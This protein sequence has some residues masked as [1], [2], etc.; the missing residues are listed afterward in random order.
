MSNPEN[1][2]Y[3]GLSAFD[4]FLTNLKALFVKKTD[5]ASSSTSGISKLYNDTGNNTDGSINQKKITEELSTKLPYSGG[6]LTGNIYTTPYYNSTITNPDGGQV[7][8]ISKGKNNKGTHPSSISETH[9]LGVATDKTGDIS[10]LHKYGHVQTS[11]NTSGVTTTEI[12]AFKDTA[13]ANNSATISVSIDANGNISTSAPTPASTSNDTNIATTAFVKNEVSNYTLKTDITSG[14]SNGS[15]AVAGIDIPVTGLSAVATSG[16][17]NDLSNTPTNHVTSDTDQNITSVKTFIGTKTIH[18]KQSGT[19]DKLGFTL[20]TN[21]DIEKGYLEYNPTNLVNGI[22]LLMLGNYA[23]S[24]NALAYTGFRRYSNISGANGAYNLLTPLISDAKT[25]FNLTTTYTNFYLTLGVTDGTNMV[26]TAK[27]GVLDIST[28]LPTVPTNI[29]AFTN[30]AGYITSNG[31]ASSATKLS[32][33]QAIDG[34]NFDGSAAIT[35]YGTCSTTAGTAA[36]T[37]ACTSY[38]LTTGSRI[39]VKFTVTNTADNPTLNVNNTG[40]KAIQYRGTAITAGHLAANRTYEF[41]YDGTNYQLVGD[42]DTGVMSVTASSTNG[43]VSVDGTD[44]TVYTHPTTDGNKHIPSGGSSG[45]IL[46][47]S[48]AGTAEWANEYSYTHPTYTARTGKPTA[49]ATPAFGGTFTVSQI[50][51]DVTGHVTGATDRTITIP[52]ATATTSA[53]GLMSATDKTKLDGI[54]T[55]ANAYT[56]PAATSSALGGVIVGSN[57]TNT[58]GTI[59]LT[60]AN[61]TTALGYTPPTTDN[62]TKNTAGSTD[63]SSKL[64]LIG[65]T[66]Q[67]ANPQTYSHD[68]AFVDTNGRLN[69]AAPDSNANDNTVA[70]TKWVKDQSYITGVAWEDITN[71]PSTFTPPTASSTTLGGIKV[72]TNLSISNGVLSA[73]DTTYNDMVGATSSVNGTHGLVPA[74]SSGDQTKFLCGN[75]TWQTVQ[76]S[77]YLPM[78]ASE[79]SEG[80]S[81]IDRVISAKVLHDKIEEYDDEHVISDDE[82]LELWDIPNSADI[83][84]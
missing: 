66:L 65:A 59:S 71:K 29:S 55:G 5:S 42:I 28:L 46:K 50:T 25:P 54:D 44:I 72:G 14:T 84:Y 19:N 34:V 12:A 13:N 68:T 83:Y 22:P 63:T 76:G 74:P 32:T 31:T 49:N 47:Y 23:T 18:F 73:V 33:A 16:N 52:S 51:S 77:E 58:S 27:T 62:D 37:V 2:K 10:S 6:T 67:A 69:S 64:F 30:D 79:A 53:A 15:I 8:I 48:A 17:Y 78:T 7:T 39:I 61:V 75:G 43:K 45:Q 81:T 80:V 21:G 4:R 41:I 26:R 1:K 24:A 11:I 40:A 56:L 36:K 82:I 60:K 57:I 20:F 9:I 3:G 35:H 70:T 38:T